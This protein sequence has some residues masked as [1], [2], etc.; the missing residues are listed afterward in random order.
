PPLP[1]QQTAAGTEP[2]R[3]RSAGDRAGLLEEG[4]QLPEELFGNL[5]G[6]ALRAGGGEE[7]RLPSGAPAEEDRRG[8]LAFPP[9][10]QRVPERREDLPGPGT[11]Q[12]PPAGLP[13]DPHAAGREADLAEEAVQD[14][15]EAALARLE[16]PHGE[17]GLEEEPEPGHLPGHRPV[18]V[19]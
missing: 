1:A 6:G 16:G 7:R 4:A 17:A 12:R 5:G 11:G 2:G 10:G 14:G 19:E 9:A 18:G 13:R 15:L 3:P 8:A